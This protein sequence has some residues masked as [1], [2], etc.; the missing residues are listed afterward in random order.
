MAL[1]YKR[2]VL[3]GIVAAFFLS[4]YGFGFIPFVFFPD[5]DRNMITVDI[6][7]PQGTRVEATQNVIKDIDGG[8]AYESSENIC[9]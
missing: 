7:L 9:D 6:N 1:A 2:L 8:T 5:S 4:L 3:F